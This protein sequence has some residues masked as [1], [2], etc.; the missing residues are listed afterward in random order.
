[1]SVEIVGVTKTGKYTWIGE[2]PTEYIYLPFSQRFSPSMV[3]LAESFGHP[4]ALGW[5]MRSVVTQ[6][7]ARQPIYNVRTL[8]DFFRKRVLDAPVLITQIVSAMGLLAL[9]LALAGLYGLI[10]YG[11]SRRTR[12]IG[13]RMAIGADRGS[14]LKMVLRQGLR[15]SL[16]GLLVGLP[17]SVAAAKMTGAVLFEARSDLAPILLVTPLLLAVTMAAAYVPARRASKVEPMRAL[18]YE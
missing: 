17:V 1:M 15:V 9:F 13:I 5:P 10:A 2:N 16:L 12:E 3:V 4:A 6:L 7:D 11:V 14:V 8:D 18:R